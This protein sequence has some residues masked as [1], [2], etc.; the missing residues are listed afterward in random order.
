MAALCVALVAASTVRAQVTIPPGLEP[1]QVQQQ[2]RQMRV[3]PPTSAVVAPRVPEQVAPSQAQDLRFVL[4]DVQIDGLKAYP[5]AELARA[6]APMLGNEISVAQVFAV[7]NQLTA[8]FRGDGY[9]LSQVLVPAQNIVEGHVRLVAV[10]GFI[11]TVQFRGEVGQ[12]ALLDSYAASLRNARPLTAKVLER[13]LLLMNDLPHTTARG[14]LVPST[15]VEGAADLVIDVSRR[16]ETVALDVNNRNSRSLGPWR[17]NADFEVDDLLSTWDAV[18]LGAGWSPHSE[19]AYGN[20]S[21]AAPL[22]Y[23]GAQWSLGVTGV[24][25]RPGPAANLAITD[26][27]TESVAANLQVSYSLLRSRSFNLQMRGAMTSFDGQSEFSLGTVSDDRLR[28]ASGGT[29]ARYHGSLA[30]HHDGRCRVLARIERHR[31]APDRNAGFTAVAHQRSD[32]LFEGHR[33]CGTSAV[34]RIPLVRVIRR[35]RATGVYHVAGTRV[36]RFR[37]RDH[38]PRLRRRRVGG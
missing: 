28:S 25:A 37:R 26:L 20:L 34:A 11:A 3:P 31:R 16:P 1:G 4:R 24:R 6:F 32:G 29:C 19:L 8:R 30:G 9:I 15:Q 27:K 12:S 2:L 21:Y 13:Y 10:E 7:A 35:L 23:R 17:A 5:Q 36:V 22:G 18:T 38:G 14:T 33:V